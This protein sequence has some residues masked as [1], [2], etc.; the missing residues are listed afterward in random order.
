[1]LV[2]V[3]GGAD[4]LQARLQRHGV[5]TRPLGGFGLSTHLRVSVG[6]RDENERFLK[7]LAAELRR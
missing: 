5:I 6:T 1:M 3:G 7:S 2:E 4:A